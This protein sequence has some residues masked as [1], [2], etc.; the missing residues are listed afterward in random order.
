V[1]M[2]RFSS[3]FR[4]QVLCRNETLLR[5]ARAVVRKAGLTGEAVAPPNAVALKASSRLT[6]P[7]S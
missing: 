2:R 7:S 1:L 6:R 4:D 5:F 3:E